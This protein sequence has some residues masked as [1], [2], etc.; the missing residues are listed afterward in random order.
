MHVLVN[1]WNAMDRARHLLLGFDLPI[2]AT[3][4]PGQMF[5]APRLPH[6]SDYGE[7]QTEHQ[8]GVLVSILIN[9]SHKFGLGREILTKNCCIFIVRVTVQWVRVYSI[10]TLY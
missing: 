3:V 8:D 5:S 1:H 10:N 7:W 9:G 6:L 4:H 2:Q